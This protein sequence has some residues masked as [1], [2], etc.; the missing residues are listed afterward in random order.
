METTRERVS[1][2]PFF[3][4][5]VSVPL[6]SSRVLEL[7]VVFFLNFVPRFPSA[8]HRRGR[9]NK[10]MEGLFWKKNEKKDGNDG[11]DIVDAVEFFFGLFLLRFYLLRPSPRKWTSN[12][13]KSEICPKKAV[14]ISL[15]VDTLGQRFTEFYRVLFAGFSRSVTLGLVSLVGLG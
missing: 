3:R 5:R 7:F 13:K 6:H 15:V 4:F 1:G 8:R 12:W 9:K 11:V 10:K 2:V 14:F